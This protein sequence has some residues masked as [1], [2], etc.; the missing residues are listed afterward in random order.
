M[1]DN[2]FDS[3]QVQMQTVVRQLAMLPTN[4]VADCQQQHV[5]C[6]PTAS[7][8]Q[9]SC[10]SCSQPTDRLSCL[11][12]RQPARWCCSCW[13]GS[14]RSHLCPNHHFQQKPRTRCRAIL[15]SQWQSA[16][17]FTGLKEEK[18]EEVE[19]EEEAFFLIWQQAAA[20]L[21][22]MVIQ[23]AMTSGSKTGNLIEG[24]A[25]NM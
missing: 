8:A 4:P 16:R 25:M 22:C 21:G 24:R 19:E 15:L 14:G 11:K 2:A 1:T 3:Q 7:P 20:V 12:P 9:W 23:N 18:E 6:R 5:V 10:R 13:R 17:Q